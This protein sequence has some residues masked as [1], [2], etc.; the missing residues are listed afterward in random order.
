M[1]LFVAFLAV[2]LIEIA[3]F[4]QVG[5]AIGLFP[6]LAIVVLTAILGTFSS[7]M[8]FSGPGPGSCWLRAP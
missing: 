8:W 7:A 4:I 6:T 3:L 1:W 5:G 2:P